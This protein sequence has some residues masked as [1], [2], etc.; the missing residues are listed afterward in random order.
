MR[1]IRKVAA[2]VALGLACMVVANTA[3]YGQ[4]PEPGELSNIRFIEVYSC[5]APDMIPNAAGHFPGTKIQATLVFYKTQLVEVYPE[6]SFAQV[7]QEAMS[8]LRALAQVHP[9]IAAESGKIIGVEF[10]HRRVTANG[11]D[12]CP[13]I[14]QG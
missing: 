9:S 1:G 7:K 10:I 2:I 8:M 6:A 13:G 5:P 11:V 3:A 14:P 12:F 4:Q